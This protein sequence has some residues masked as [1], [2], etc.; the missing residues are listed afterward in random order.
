MSRVKAST[1]HLMSHSRYKPLAFSEYAE[2]Y[3]PA[4]LQ[5]TPEFPRIFPKATTER[6]RRQMGRFTNQPR[7]PLQYASPN[8]HFDPLSI[9]A[10]IDC[11]L[12][13]EIGPY[14]NAGNLAYELNRSYEQILWDPVT[15]GRILSD[16]SGFAQELKMPSPQHERPLYTRKHGGIRNYVIHNDP[17]GWQWLG[18]VREFMGRAA[19][20]YV[21]ENIRTRN[22]DLWTPVLGFKYGQRVE[23]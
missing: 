17:N 7:G 10:A 3:A 1:R 9:A 19:E 11:I 16:I 20:R 15:V 22:V 2:D 21:R 18:L 5:M 4:A 12:R 13:L 6:W 8:G 14:I 23:A